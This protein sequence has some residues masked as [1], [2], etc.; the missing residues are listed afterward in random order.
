MLTGKG[1]R[2]Q[3]SLFP[4]NFLS[5]FLSFLFSF[6]LP[7]KSEQHISKERTQQYKKLCAVYIPGYIFIFL[8]VYPLLKNPIKTLSQLKCLTPEKY[9][10]VGVCRKPFFVY[11]KLSLIR[12]ALGIYCPCH[13]NDLPKLWRLPPAVLCFSSEPPD[14]LYLPCTIIHCLGKKR[15][16]VFKRKL[17]PFFSHYLRR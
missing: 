17:L 5:L 8:S 4:L 13:N 2:T 6:P 7:V 16:P 3:L 9:F 11:R 10:F 12:R 1:D 15:D 14:A